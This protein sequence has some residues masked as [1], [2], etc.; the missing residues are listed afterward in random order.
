MSL[1]SSYA[2]RAAMLGLRTAARTVPMAATVAGGID[3]A[4]YVYK[5][6][7][8]ALRTFYGK[9]KA[10]RRVSS[11]DN[12]R[13]KGL[14]KKNKN[15]KYSKL[16]AA[17]KDGFV[18]RREVGDVITDKDNTAIY[19]AHSTMPQRLVTITLWKAMIKRLFKSKGVI[20]KN[21]SIPLLPN[22]YN[23]NEI[24]LDYKER[25]G[26]IVKTQ[27]WTITLN[28]TTLD[29]LAAAIYTW[30]NTNAGKETCPKICLRIQLVEIWVFALTPYPMEPVTIDLTELKVEVYAKSQL[31]IQNRTINSTGNDTS[32]DV[33]NVPI[34]GKFFEF[35]TNGTIFRDYATPSGTGGSNVT[36]HP[37]TGC[38]P[39]LPP[40]TTGT[41]MYKSVPLVSQLVGVKG[42]GSAHLNPGEIKTS[43][44]KDSLNV[45]FNRLISLLYSKTD[46]GT[47]A[48]DG[49]QQYWIGTTR[50]YG[51]EKQINAVVPTL[52]NQFNLA[53]E[54]SIEI[55]VVPIVRNNYHTAP[56][57]DKLYSGGL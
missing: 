12:A 15:V 34:H 37:Q 5:G 30:F 32:D 7:K 39:D 51:F 29:Q 20:I 46:M 9:K 2:R 33:D 50:L 53:Y 57:V 42:T 40:V 44:M 22:S 54:H 26:G 48:N 17:S 47:N 6:A 27:S 31:K 45:G 23:D 36:T 55:G 52:E 38:L 41:T 25:D 21:D 56:R 13:S 1:G 24:R 3:A 4:N 49:L 11:S 14:F 18:S 35:K 16:D 28:T 19:V 10:T 43:V 8:S